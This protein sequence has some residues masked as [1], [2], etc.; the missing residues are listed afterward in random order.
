MYLTKKHLKIIRQ[1][2]KWCL[3]NR[4]KYCIPSNLETMCA[5]ASARL[6]KNL[7]KANLNPILKLSNYHCW[8]EFS[9]IAIDI[10]ATQFGEAPILIMD[11]LNYYGLLRQKGYLEKELFS[12]NNYR[13]FL[14][15]LKL[16]PK[17]QRPDF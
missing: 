6:Y 16:W 17:S 13:Q 4:F 7:R 11:K 3:A 9:D 8:I 14:R 2:R 10:T 12:Y 15:H 1:T 5:I